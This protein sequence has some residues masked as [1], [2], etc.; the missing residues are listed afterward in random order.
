[1]GA[2]ALVIG[3]ATAQA[4]SKN[5]AGR[6][7][8]TSD[9]KLATLKQLISPFEVGATVG[10]EFT[11]LSVAVTQHN[12]GIVVLRNKE[13]AT[14]QVDI[15]R[16]HEDDSSIASTQY[17]SLFLRNGGDGETPTNESQGVAVMRLGEAIRANEEN[18]ARLTLASKK[19]FWATATTS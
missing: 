9:R 13:R 3:A 12:T 1:V 5:L 4:D 15:C 7:E 2:G 17:Y 19:E 18:A 6:Q 16:R 14:I 10:S 8:G 11:L